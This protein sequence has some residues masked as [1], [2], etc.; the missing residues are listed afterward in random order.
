[1]SAVKILPE[2]S[3]T[4]APLGAGS[5]QKYKL[6][7][8]SNRRKVTLIANY[9]QPSEA[10]RDAVSAV[11]L[12]FITEPNKARPKAAIVS[13]VFSNSEEVNS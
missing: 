9:I 10:Q 5:A 1:M 11:L 6:K 2:N 7:F 4:S 8:N 13:G 12:S 3:T